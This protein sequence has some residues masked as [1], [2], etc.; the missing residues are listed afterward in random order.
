MLEERFAPARPENM[1]VVQVLIKFGDLIQEAAQVY[2]MEVER[3]MRFSNHESFQITSGEFVKYFN[4][5]L[6]MRICHVTNTQN[7]VTKSYKPYYRNVRIPAFMDTLIN[8][9]GVAEDIDFG[10]RFVPS[11]DIKAEELLSPEELDNISRRLDYIGREGLV[12]TEN[13]LNVKPA[14]ELQVMAMFSIHNEVKSYK[15]DHPIYGFY[16]AFFKHEIVSEVLE[17]KFLRIR[18]GANTEYVPIV[19][20]IVKS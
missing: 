14:G 18:Y 5:L 16:A 11:M 12:I 4:T 8:S 7:Q 19:R 1:V 15:K 3:V 10:F 2:E 20:E 13:G 9:I 17:P 6:Y